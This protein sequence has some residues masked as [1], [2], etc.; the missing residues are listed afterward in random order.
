MISSQRSFL[1][2][3]GSAPAPATE[4][5]PAHRLEPPAHRPEATNTGPEALSPADREAIALC[6]RLGGFTFP[7][8]MNRA[9]EL[10]LLKTFC[11]PSI[12]GLLA[13]SGEFEQRPRKRYDD[14][15]LMVAE[16]LRHGPDSPTGEAVIQRM[17]RIHAAFAIRP[18]DYLY[19][20][21]GFVCEPIRWL[22]RFGWRALDPGEEEAL[23]RFWQQVGAR[24]GIAT[25]PATL[26]ELTAF[27]QA[28]EAQAFV[29]ADS[30]RQVADATRAMLL[31]DWPRPLRPLL[32]AGLAGLLE[33]QAATSLGWQRP[34][35]LLRAG[36]L[37]ALRLR[38][39]LAGTWQR[40]RPPRAS[41]FYSE[42][43][44]P[45]YGA[46]FRLEQLGPPAQ[47]ERLNRP[48]WPGPQWRLGLTGG[49]AS[50]KSAVAALLEQ[51]HGLPVLDADRYAREALAPGRAATRAV[52]ERYGDRVRQR[53][54]PLDR[55]P[56]GDGALDRAALGQIVFHDPA[57]R[58]WLEQLVHPLVRQRFEQE[59]QRLA[60][61]PAV[62]LMIPLLLEASLEELCSEVWLVDCLEDQQ[63]ARLMARDGLEEH[64][65]RARIEAQWPLARKRALVER[66]VD[67]RGE[68]AALPAVVAATLAEAQARR[69]RPAA[70]PRISP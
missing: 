52:L 2:T 43:P 33:P 63:L 48:R 66:C 15:A 20:L 30:N 28:Y 46:H 53:E 22:K 35:S 23:F 47:L 45:S 44:T 16:L 19:V 41:R 13:R 27:H 40:L 68:A 14:T 62:V 58:R 42:R 51:Q 29:E 3:E 59:L 49:I 60:D 12:S 25:I 69:I 32:A 18:N 54:A 7:W 50:G 6:Q 24:M 64:Q 17:N 70:P 36:V 38:S 34:P 10:A 1:H 57:E 21:S 65:A 61:A 26:A 67:N 37:G 8:D 4:S 9:L 39:R 5:P 11:V 55:P 56:L 31:R